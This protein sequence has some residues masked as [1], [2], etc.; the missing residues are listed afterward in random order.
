[1]LNWVTVEEDFQPK[2]GNNVVCEVTIRIDMSIDVDGDIEYDI[3]TMEVDTS[4]R[5]HG[6]W[7]SEW[8][9]APDWLKDMFSEH[10]K[11]ADKE[12]YYDQINSRF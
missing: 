1:M 3:S 11:T 12:W 2:I 5:K 8:L 6:T 7:A 9:E 10:F 4:Y